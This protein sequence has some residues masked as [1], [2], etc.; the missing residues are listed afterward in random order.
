MRKHSTKTVLAAC[1]AAVALSG[2]SSSGPTWYQRGHSDGQAHIQQFDN[3]GWGPD[4]SYDTIN[5]YCTGL[6]PGFPTLSADAQ[7]YDGCIAAIQTG[8]S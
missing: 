3:L 4:P 6:A 7:W 5:A 2:C 8:A 1:A